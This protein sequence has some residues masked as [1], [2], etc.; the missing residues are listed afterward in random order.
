MITSI[1]KLGLTQLIKNI[2]RPAFGKGTCIDWILTNSEHV[3][4]SFGLN[5]LISDHYPVICVLNKSLECKDKEPKLVRLYNR[6]DFN[7][8]GA[9]VKNLDWTLFENENDVDKKWL[10]IKENVMNIIEVMC[11]LKKM[12]VR[13]TQPPR[14]NNNIAGLTCDR[15]RLS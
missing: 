15:E 5:N 14:F 13:K 4:M 3:S 10:F 2:T 1:R 8:L 11:P 6:L 12:Y 9:L 7:V